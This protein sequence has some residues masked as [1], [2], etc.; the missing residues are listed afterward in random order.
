MPLFGTVSSVVRQVLGGR[1]FGSKVSEPSVR[2]TPRAPLMQ[3]L[4][5]RAMFAAAPAFELVVEQSSAP[6]GPV[7]VAPAK[8]AK[9]PLA[10]IS[11]APRVTAGFYD[12]I[13][14]TGGQDASRVIP[15]LRELGIT[16]VRIWVGMNSW[17]HRGNG[18]AFLQA[19]K[20]KDAG[21]KVMMNVGV[22]ATASEGTY[23]GFFNWLKSQKNFKSVD[24]MQIG[25]EPNHYK[26]WRGGIDGYMKL[27]KIASNTLRPTGMKIL[28]AGP[29]AGA[30]ACKELVSKGYLKYVDYAGF[31]AYG[32]SAREAIARLKAAK[33]YY[34]NKPLI[35]SE[36][37][38]RNQT[39]NNAWA[40]E[41]KAVRRDIAKYCNAAFYFSLVKGGSMAGPAGVFANTSWTPN[42]PFYDAVKTFAYMEGGAK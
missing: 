24:M 1:M 40:N 6:L 41:L 32:S 22:A 2:K 23:Q 31:H 30:E 20:Y 9:A 39:N 33:A 11:S 29:T 18:Q 4:E 35:V 37:N 12:G 28:G 25:N 16:G 5:G 7:Y 27:L 8:V 3:Q 13:N 21:I 34:G 15:K 10:S 36:W 42:G 17:N 26:S 38:I 14:V 19:Q